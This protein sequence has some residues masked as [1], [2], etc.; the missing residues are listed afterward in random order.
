MG[1]IF[2]IQSLKTCSELTIK[3]IFS[4][5]TNN[6]LWNMRLSRSWSKMQSSPPAESIETILIVKRPAQ[7]WSATSVFRDSFSQIGFYCKSFG[8][9]INYLKSSDDP[10]HGT[11]DA[12]FTPGIYGPRCGS[13]GRLR[14]IVFEMKPLSSLLHA[15]VYPLPQWIAGRSTSRSRY[16]S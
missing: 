10:C 14:Q 15:V 9:P 7:F 12:H 13:K 1:D 3:R 5:S 6:K 16:C 8:K 4:I 11:T 2:A